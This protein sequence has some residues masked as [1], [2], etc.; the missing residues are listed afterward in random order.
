MPSRLILTDGNR[1]DT[2]IET[3]LSRLHIMNTP[4]K[5]RPHG[6]L[7]PPARRAHVG[8]GLVRTNTRL[9]KDDSYG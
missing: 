5:M 6:E 8:D 2:I 3:P 4:P 9:A 1:A 7:R